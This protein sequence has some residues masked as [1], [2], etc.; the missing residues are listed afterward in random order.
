MA[1]LYDGT[2]IFIG[3]DECETVVP[4]HEA[5]EDDRWAA[6]VTGIWTTTTHLCPDCALSQACEA[7]WRDQGAGMGEDDL[8]A[9]NAEI[10]A[11]KR[12]PSGATASMILGLWK[13]Y[14][15]SGA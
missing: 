5:R 4:L 8:S 2:D 3:C 1:E 12:D 11:A 10:K 6:V 14:E 7:Y 15:P 13:T 9:L